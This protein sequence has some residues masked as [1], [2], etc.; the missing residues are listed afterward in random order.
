MRRTL[1]LLLI[2]FLFGGCLSL[3]KS[4]S[5]LT[6]L[7][8]PEKLKSDA[9]FI[10]GKLQKL[11]PC[12]D[13]YTSKKELD[14]KFDSLK[15]SITSPMTSNEFFFRLSPVIAAI[16]Q[17]H[18]R[19]SPINKK[20]SVKHEINPG[21]PG[22]LQFF[23]YDF[24]MFD[25]RFYITKNIGGHKDIKPPSELVSVNNHTPQ[26]ILRKYRNT[27]TSDGFNQTFIERR[28]SKDLPSYLYYEDGL[29]DSV[30]C[31]LRYRDTLLRVCLRRNT[32]YRAPKVAISRAQ[33]VEERFA[34]KKENSK[35]EEQ[36]YNE[37]TRTYSKNLSFPVPDSSI[38]I[39]KINDFSDGNH[40][41]FYRET[42]RLLD[43]LKT[44]TLILDIRDNPGG[45]LRDAADLFSY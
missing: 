16:R 43:T 27:L 6:A 10:Y 42:F 8:S 35:R 23:Q 38:A 15:L 39:L 19:V 11:H 7:H 36:G 3:E 14:F 33:R 37:I 28:L 40:Q 21:M 26:E 5:S 31:E 25:N 17:G 22:T 9:D 45:E 44:K 30:V 20:L 24:E 4:T 41:K 2:A 12:L 29:A 1:I 18:T 13:N 32:K 34:R